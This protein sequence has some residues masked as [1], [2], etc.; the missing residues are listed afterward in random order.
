MSVQGAHGRLV[1]MGAWCAKRGCGALLTAMKA[2]RALTANEEARHPAL[3]YNA[4]SMHRWGLALQGTLQCITR[5]GA[6]AQ[7]RALG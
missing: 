3:L 5:M 4:R 1:R 2:E 6:C 7:T